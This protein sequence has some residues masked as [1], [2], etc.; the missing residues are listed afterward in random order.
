MDGESAFAPRISKRSQAMRTVRP[1]VVVGVLALASASWA[2]FPDDPPNDPDWPGQHDARGG[3]VGI[4]TPNLFA[5]YPLATDAEGA[6]G[7][8]ADLAWRDGRADFGDAA[9]GRPDV[10][11]AYMEG[12][13]NWHTPSAADLL[14]KIYINRAEI[15]GSDNYGACQR[16]DN[17]DPWY[18][19]LD[20]AHCL[21]DANGNGL[22]DAEDAIVFFSDGVDDDGNGYVDDISG[23]DFYNN[24]NDPATV[25][26][27]YVHCNAQMARGAAAA[28]NGIGR[29]GICPLCMIMPVKEGAEAIDRSDEMAQAFVFA[30]DSGARAFISETADLG[31]STFMR[32]AV[33]HTWRRNVPGSLATNDFDSTD[34]QGGMFWPHV[35]GCNSLVAS[36][37]GVPALPGVPPNLLATTFRRRSGQTSWGTKQWVSVATDGG[38]TSASCG[39]MLGVLGLMQSWSLEAVDRGYLASPLSASE[40]MQV[41]R[42]SAS[43]VQP[44]DDVAWPVRAGWD[45]QTGYGR[46]N[47]RRAQQMIA[48]GN[49][50][51]QAWFLEP[52]WYSLHD[53][54]RESAI[55]IT[56][57]LSAPRS[58]YYDWTLEWAAVPGG[59]PTDA[60]F[61]PLAS[62]HEVA[63]RAGVLGHLPL[64]SVAAAFYEATYAT[65]DNRIEAE[66]HLPATEQYTVT[67]RLR[68]TD[69][70]GRVGEERRAIAVHNDA[71]WFAGFPL[72]ANAN[73]AGLEGGVK[74]ADL[75]GRGHLAI[76][77]ADM[78]GYVHALDPLSRQE[79]P[80]WPVT[81]DPT[82]TERDL[83]PIG[84]L[85]RFEPVP[86]PIA[87]GDLDG[88]GH[89]W[90]VVTTTT[91]RVYAFDEHGQRRPGW[92]RALDTG[93]LPPSV[94]RVPVPF[95]RPPAA[96]A[97]TSPVLHD[98]DGDGRL[99]VIQSAWDGHLHIFR[100]DGSE[101]PGWPVKVELPAS[102]QPPMGYVTIQDEKLEAAPAIV[103]LDA[104]PQWELVIRSQQ[105]DTLGT[106]IQPLGLGH[107]LAYDTDGT[108]LWMTTMQSAIIYHGSAQEF[109]T[110]G[111][112]SPVAADLDGDGRHEVAVD[113]VFSPSIYVYNPDGSLRLP[114]TATSA[115]GLPPLD[116]GGV[117]VPDAPVSFTTGGAF[118]RFGAAGLLSF[119]QA[120]SNA[121]SI[122]TGLLVTGSGEPIVN[123]ERAFDALTGAALPGFPSILQGLNFLGSPLFVDVSGDGQAEILDG[124]DSSALHGFDSLGN[125]APGF[126]KFTTGWMLWS[127]TAGDL[128]SD[129]TV[130]VLAGTREGYLMAW[131]TAGLASANVEWWTY[132]HDEWNT[133]RYGA[134]TRPPGILRVPHLGG[135][136]ILAF[137]APGDDWY[138]GTVAGYRLVG[139][140]GDTDLPGAAPA[141]DEES[142]DVPAGIDAWRAA[143][144]WSSTMPTPPSAAWYG[145][146]RTP[147][148][149]RRP[150]ATRRPPSAPRSRCAMP[151]AAS[152]WRSSCRRPAGSRRAPAAS[153]IAT[154]AE[155]W[156]RCAAPSCATVSSPRSSPAA[157]ASPSL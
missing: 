102:Y 57:H 33:E 49:I 44:P 132:R 18:N 76:V 138:A 64:A 89:L 22:A 61:Q 26:A 34:H 72:P 37:T 78:D 116:L 21:P 119:A 125:A 62:A 24:Q 96:G 135:A 143:S 157:A 112:S 25:D 81:T 106:D 59:E 126:P 144:C 110:E 156:A 130:E 145:S 14:P 105:S 3:N 63:P 92:P 101:L 93:V 95:S 85:P 52:R 46:V 94:P 117:P 153:A 35:I 98:M 43:D 91:G 15:E 60:Q 150:A 20:F 32:Q 51:P 36:T 10:V 17:G 77:Y 155:R 50:P 107:A 99:E 140:D 45:L 109:I 152:R 12:G 136:R 68:V 97:G 74:L 1:L 27:E 120:G 139:A 147:P 42:A 13:I 131:E 2:A 124:G 23:W 65:N 29:A 69:A 151:R 118:G 41:L 71:S 48:A 55:E 66:K 56:G 90:V 7:M 88:D 83:T 73:R 70:A 4:G 128:D 113:P 103:N 16:L 108:Q 148:S 111:S 127:A 47:L 146:P 75:Q 5:E 104:D 8:S 19:S 38:S 79:L 80:G 31:Y 40:V 54:A 6:S 141:G 114:Y 30:I 123:V 129:G 11:V 154:R 121:L 9:M 133:G 149:R 115:T 134:D 87:V 86:L 39:V 67:L 58:N 137:T 28:D 100:G 122:A 84:I 53:P 142:L 82:L